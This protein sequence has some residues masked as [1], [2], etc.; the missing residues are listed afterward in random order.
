MTQSSPCVYL[1]VY[2]KYGEWNVR[3]GISEYI[4][5]AMD[6][7]ERE[8]EKDGMLKEWESMAEEEQEDL[9]LEKCQNNVDKQR[10]W[11]TVLRVPGTLVARAK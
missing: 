7:L 2:Y 1:E 6:E 11:G 8:M 9:A 5:D 10:G 3:Q 4:D